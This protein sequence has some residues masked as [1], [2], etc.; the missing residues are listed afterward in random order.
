MIT[1]AA[2]AL[3]IG[4]CA[5]E[6]EIKQALKADGYRWA[7][8]GHP[9]GRP[10]AFDDPHEGSLHRYLGPQG[11]VLIGVRAGQWCV[12]HIQPRRP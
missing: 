4:F 6:V 8:T 5:F 11:T 12:N 3:V 10:P 7:A 2:A 1:E 9:G